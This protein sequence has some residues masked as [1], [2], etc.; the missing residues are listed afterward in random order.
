MRKKAL[1]WL[2]QEIAVLEEDLDE[3]DAYFGPCPFINLVHQLQ[4]EMTGADVSFAAPLSF[5]SVI[6]KG[7]ITVR[8]MFKLYKYENYLYTLKLTGKEIKDI[9]ELSYDRSISSL[10]L[11]LFKN[12]KQSF[13]QIGSSRSIFNNSVHVK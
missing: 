11:F 1:E 3:T 2:N 13:S 8:D 7:I 6:P 12:C 4:L 5:D 10:P 9:L